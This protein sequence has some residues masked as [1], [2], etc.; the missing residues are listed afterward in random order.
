MTTSQ[1]Y[2]TNESQEASPFPAGDSKA[3]INKHARKH[4]QDRNNINDHTRNEYEHCHLFNLGFLTLNTLISYSIWFDIPRRG[5]LEVPKQSEL[6]QPIPRNSLESDHGRTSR[7]YFDNA[8]DNMTLTLYYVT[9]T[10]QKPCLH[11]Y[12]CDC[13]KSN[14][15]NEVY[16][17]NINFFYS[18]E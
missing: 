2:I 15:S 14:G 17:L 6:P 16:V 11:N 9:L 1:L 5:M 12:K 10:S 18:A 4:N 13:N 8:V 7:I 3:P